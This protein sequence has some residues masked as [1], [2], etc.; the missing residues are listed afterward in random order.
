ML[1]KTLLIIINSLLVMSFFSYGMG[2]RPNENLQKNES[3]KH[4][5]LYTQII[6]LM[7]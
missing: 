5:I 3:K 6:M 7:D 4:H 2:K 1:K